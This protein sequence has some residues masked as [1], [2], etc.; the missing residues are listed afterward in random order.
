MFAG[1][2]L[3]LL[4]E[5]TVKYWGVSVE[6]DVCYHA[7]KIFGHALVKLIMSLL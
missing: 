5:G 7:K 2:L 6:C 4:A 3:H 1:D